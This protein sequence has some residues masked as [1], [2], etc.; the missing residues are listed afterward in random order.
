LIKIWGIVYNELPTQLMMKQHCNVLQDLIWQIH[1]VVDQKCYQN[2]CQS[3][4]PKMIDLEEDFQEED[5]P[6][7]EAFQGVEVD[8]WVTEDIWE[9]EEAC[10]ELDP[11]V[12]DGDLHQFMCLRLTKEKWWES[13]LP[14][15]MEIKSRCNSSLINGSCIGGSITTTPS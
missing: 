5:T 1:L 9:E 12:E 14:S 2:S 15:F 7:V 3:N 10:Q 4:Y 11:Q 6:E 13:H 8:S